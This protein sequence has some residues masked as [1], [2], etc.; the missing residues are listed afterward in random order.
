[1]YSMTG[2]RLARDGMAHGGACGDREGRGD[3]GG[4]GLDLL[5]LAWHIGNRHVP[6]EITA[7][8]LYI[9]V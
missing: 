6:A 4:P 8:A 5:T 1:M 3:A 7:D 2:T 9:L